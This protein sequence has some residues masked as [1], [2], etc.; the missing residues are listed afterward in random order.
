MRS[1]R[2]AHIETMKGHS[3]ALD[4]LRAGRDELIDTYSQRIRAK[5]QRLDTLGSQVDALLEKAEALEARLA[6]APKLESTLHARE[7]DS[8]LKLVLAMAIKGYGYD[9]KAHRNST[10]KEIAGNSALIGI[11]MD[12]D[13]V[14]KYLTE[15]KEHLPQ[16]ETEPNS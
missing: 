11:S 5:D 15:A 3:Q 9:P 10:S 7:R 12:E 13:T 6:S 8:L 16:V 2:A 14:R 4:D 1:E